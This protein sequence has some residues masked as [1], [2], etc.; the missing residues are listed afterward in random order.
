VPVCAIDCDR[1]V[2]SRL[3]R[4]RPCGLSFVVDLRVQVEELQLARHGVLEYGAKSGLAQAGGFGEAD[5]R[6]AAH[7]RLL[8]METYRSTGD[9]DR[10]PGIR[11]L[12]LMPA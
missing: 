1:C 7:Q 2:D 10:P 8:V 9:A 6:N 11:G 5:Q 4:R 3:V 12:L